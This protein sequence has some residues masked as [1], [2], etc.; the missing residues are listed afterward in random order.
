VRSNRIPGTR[1][2]SGS[3]WSWSAN[4]KP[5]VNLLLGGR[6]GQH[7]FDSCRDHPSLVGPVRSGRRPVK[8][9]NAG[10]NP[11][12]GARARSKSD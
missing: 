12:R 8:A 11:V 10:S 9:E 5:P 1:E 4:D 7:R 6:N 3:P 2:P